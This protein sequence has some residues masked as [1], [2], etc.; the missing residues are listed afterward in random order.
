MYNQQIYEE[1]SQ[2]FVRMRDGEDDPSVQGALMD[3]L[4]RSPEHVSAYLDIAAIWME[5]KHVQAD[6]HLDLAARIAAARADRGVTELA[7]G[8]QQM[9]RRYLNPRALLAVAASVFIVCVGV[10]AAWWHYGREVYSTALGEQRSIALADGS[11]VELNSQSRVRVRFDKRQ[12]RIELLEG[13]ALFHVS[14]DP[15]RPFLVRADGTT[16][17]AVGTVFD[18]YRKRGAAVITVVEGVVVVEHNEKAEPAPTSAVV[19]EWPHEQGERPF[20]PVRLAAGRQAIVKP[21][22]G[23]EASPVNVAAA[24][25][26]TQ[27]ELVFEFTPLAEAAEEFNRYNARKLVIE[28]EALRAFKISAIF[29]STDS[30]SLV[31]FVQALPGVQAR[32][33]DAEIVISATPEQPSRN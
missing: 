13:Q 19:T 5:A 32:E 26:W 14:K 10:V 20:V 31:R 2:W 3:W 22:A 23:V 33:S 7:P 27:R 15:A 18:V 30:R 24:I 1:A 6:S 12:R 21:G 11:T 8:V 4:R 16:V 17:R 29:R 9:T 28:G 25:A